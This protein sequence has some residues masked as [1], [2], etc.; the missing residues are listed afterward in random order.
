VITAGTSDIRVAEEVKIIAEEM[1][2]RSGLHTMSG[3][4]ASTA[5]SR[6]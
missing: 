4:P 6:P 1:D 2:V 5:F 3:P